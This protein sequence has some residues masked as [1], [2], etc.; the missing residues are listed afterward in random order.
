MGGHPC[1]CGGRLT[2][3]L[4]WFPAALDKGEIAYFLKTPFQEYFETAP[5][6]EPTGKRYKDITLN[7]LESFEGDYPN[8]AVTFN[9]NPFGPL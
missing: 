1:H 8:R 7:C 5:R 6:R 2:V 9:L 3:T 4:P